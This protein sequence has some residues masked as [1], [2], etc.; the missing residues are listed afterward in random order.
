M[1]DQEERLEPVEY[2]VG[3]NVILLVNRGEVWF[4]E[5]EKPNILYLAFR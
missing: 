3:I 5:R 4:P 2:T 1:V